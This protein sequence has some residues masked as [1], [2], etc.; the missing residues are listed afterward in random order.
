MKATALSLLSSI[1]VMLL[2]QTLILHKFYVFPLSEPYNPPSWWTIF[3]VFLSSG[4]IIYYMENSLFSRYFP[5]GGC[6][7]LFGLDGYLPLS[8]ACH[9]NPSYN[10]KNFIFNQTNKKS[11]FLLYCVTAVTPFIERSEGWSLR[12]VGDPGPVATKERKGVTAV[13]Q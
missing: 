4:Y 8:R 12:S 11:F 9:R 7:P 6:T 2:S 1:F 3:F 13:T 10:E 5:E